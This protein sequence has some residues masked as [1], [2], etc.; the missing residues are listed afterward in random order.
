M[1]LLGIVAIIVTMIFRTTVV[2]PAVA[3]TF[4]VALS[5]SGNLI[6]GLTAVFNASLVAAGE[7]F[8]IFLII[9]LMTALL[10]ALRALGSDVRMIVPFQRVMTNGHIA[11]IGLAIVTYL[12]SLFFWPTPAVPLVGAIL[13]PAAIAAGLPAMGAVVAIAIAGQG[14][15][16]SSDYIIRVAP[17]ISAKAAGVDIALVS[18]RAF[19]LSIVTGL[20]ALALGYLAVRKYIVQPDPG[21]LKSWEAGEALRQPAEKAGSHSREGTFPDK[22]V[23]AKSSEPAAKPAVSDEIA[24]QAS[25]LLTLPGNVERW[26]RLFAI[27]VPLAFGAIVA[28]MVLAKYSGVLPQ[29]QGGEGAALV[30]GVA[31]VILLFATLAGSGR[32]FLTHCSDHVTDGLVFAFKA[33]GSV[34]PIAGFFFIGNSETAGAILGGDAQA[35]GFLFD[36][37]Q[38]GRH[39]IPDNPFFV[40]FGLLFMGMITG[41]DGSGFSGLPLTGALAGALG[42]TVGNDPATLASIGQMG[43]IWTGGGT[44]IAWSSLIAVAGFA[45]VPVLDAVRVLFVPVMT[46]LI[47]STLLGV[48]IW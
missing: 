24:A 20:I 8:N 26:S 45:R 32:K 40:A 44:L 22:A 25:A 34:L 14:M 5:Y 21:H 41:A 37:V 36:L 31:A 19:V 13:I 2:V 28:Y 33:M 46:G 29:I 4:L 23:L 15:A 6:A 43:A 38:A 16:L 9:A 27:V 30:G 3:A 48:M 7:L 1:Y 35:P 12:I 18:D 17:G 39:A 42:Q 47:L 11:F 10:G